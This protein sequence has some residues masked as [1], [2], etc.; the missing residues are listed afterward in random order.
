MI[1]KEIRILEVDKED[2][3]K[4]LLNLGAV[5]VSEDTIQKRYVYDIDEN[6]KNKWIRLRTNGHET[7]LTVKQIIDKHS[8]AGTDEIEVRVSDFDA[9]DKLLNKMGIFHR[10]YQENIRTIYKIEDMEISID[11]WPLI[12]TYVEIEGSK[13]E[14]IIDLI[15]KF[16]IEKEKI[17][18][19]DVCSIY[20]DIYGIDILSIKNLKFG[21]EK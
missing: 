2:F 6:D 13:E 17:T 9:T 3:I 1:E 8:I 12:P 14:E 19:L 16:N 11:T 20:K 4:K 21:E 18:T 7:T 10:N 5:L 15:N